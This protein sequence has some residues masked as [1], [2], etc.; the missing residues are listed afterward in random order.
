[1]E[2]CG[3]TIAVSVLFSGENRSWLGCKGESSHSSNFEILPEGVTITDEKRTT[4]VTLARVHST[5]SD[6]RIF[7][8]IFLANLSCFHVDIAELV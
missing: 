6:D 1:M 4:V 5:S 8:H 7:I 3:S 2:D